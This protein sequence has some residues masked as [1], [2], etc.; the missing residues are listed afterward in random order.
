[1]GFA[2]SVRDTIESSLSIEHGQGWC[3]SEPGA[4]TI[5]LVF[6]EPPELK[7]ISLVFEKDEIIRTQEFVFLYR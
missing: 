6:D 5:R 2:H 4:Q 3:A 1:M 7:R